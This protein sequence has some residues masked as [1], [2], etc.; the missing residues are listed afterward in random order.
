[1]IDSAIEKPFRIIGYYY[2]S[3]NTADCGDEGLAPH[4]IDR[5]AQ[6]IKN[7]SIGN[8]CVILEVKNSLISSKDKLCIELKQFD[9]HKAVDYSMTE[10]PLRVNE[11]ID[12]MLVANVHLTELKDVEE[13]FDSNGSDDFRNVRINERIKSCN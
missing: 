5:V 3:C 11:I 7:C 10:S 4:Y 9:C 1:M 12:K 6:H 2:S 13:H 8:I